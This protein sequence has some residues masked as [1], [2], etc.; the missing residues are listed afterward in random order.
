VKLIELGVLNGAA[1]VT[2]LNLLLSGT[3]SRQLRGNA[4]NMNA[5]LSGTG[6]LNAH[7]LQTNVTSVTLSGTGSAQI[8]VQQNLSATLSGT[9]SINYHDSPQVTQNRIGT[10]SI[11]KT[12]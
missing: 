5:E 4:I 11:D 7:N 9:G 12:G 10:G 8:T 3:G 1:N 2:Q 6:N